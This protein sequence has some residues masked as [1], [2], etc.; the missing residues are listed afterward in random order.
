MIRPK[1]VNKHYAETILLVLALVILVFFIYRFSAEEPPILKFKTE[2]SDP[3]EIVWINAT[4]KSK[5]AF[6][7][8]PLEAY[9]NSYCSM[10]Y[11]DIKE[12]IPDHKVKSWFVDTFSGM[13]LSPK[14]IQYS[15]SEFTLVFL[16]ERDIAENTFYLRTVLLKKSTNG[17]II[18]KFDC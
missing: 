17:Q 15:D 14:E 7:L 1:N 5:N 16:I 3:E 18:K 2:I 4:N 8:N 11:Q 10:N 9:N 6:Y 13:R 12:L